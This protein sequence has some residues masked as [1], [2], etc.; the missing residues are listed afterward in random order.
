MHFPPKEKVFFLKFNELKKEERKE[1]ERN[2][3]GKSFPR[4]VKLVA[5]VSER[6]RA[7]R[8]PRP[9]ATMETGKGASALPIHTIPIK[10]HSTRD[11]IGP[12]LSREKASKRGRRLG[13]SS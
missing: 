1:K 4:H 6:A 5:C 12:K 7:H 2:K 8:R 3:Q 10:A 13:F 9:G 11:M